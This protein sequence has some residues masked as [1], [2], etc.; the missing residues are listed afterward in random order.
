[1]F[2]ETRDTLIAHAVK[3]TRTGG[4]HLHGRH[5][6]VDHAGRG[7]VATVALE[8]TCLSRSHVAGAD[9]L[10]GCIGGKLGTTFGT[11]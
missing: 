3:G 8:D 4:V 9:P 10:D 6:F 5:R 11:A 1:M 7:N 2:H